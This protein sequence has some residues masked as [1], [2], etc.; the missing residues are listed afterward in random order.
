ME[1]YVLLVV[2][3]YVTFSYA[4]ETKETKEMTFSV[5]HP[6]SQPNDVCICTI[7]SKS[8]QLIL[9]KIY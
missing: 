6:E 4:E 2:L 8:P 7:K 3:I 9:L 5:P 1:R